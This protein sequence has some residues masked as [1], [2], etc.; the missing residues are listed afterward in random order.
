M[1]TSILHTSTALAAVLATLGMSAAL[2]DPA[3]ATDHRVAIHIVA[4]GAGLDRSRPSDVREMYRRVARA[5]NIACGHGNRVDLEP[6]G[7]FAGCVDRAITAAVRSANLPA[8]T[9][10][11][12][13]HHGSPDAADHGVA[14]SLMAV[15]R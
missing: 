2:A 12:L 1:N 3:G 8:L 15:Q 9:E 5:A 6:V 4:S 7:D 10:V 11:Y 14:A 13:A